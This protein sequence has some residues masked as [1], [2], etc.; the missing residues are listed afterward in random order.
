MEN[1]NGMLLSHWI[2]CLVVALGIYLRLLPLLLSCLF[3]DA[4]RP[5]F[6]LPTL[7]T[8]LTL[9]HVALKCSRIKAWLLMASDSGHTSLIKEVKCQSPS[10]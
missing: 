9:H 6:F 7:P 3:R 8:L 1:T 2:D 4:C 10:L 5:F